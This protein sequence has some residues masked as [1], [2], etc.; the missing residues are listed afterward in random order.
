MIPLET[1]VLVVGAGPTGLALSV[2]LQQAGVR[3]LTVD[4]MTAGQNTSRAAVIHAHTLDVLDTLGV[5][6]RLAGLGL[7]LT[8]FC[9]RDQDHRLLSL[10]FGGLA[11]KH[12]YLV[13]LP[14]DVTEAVLTERLNEIGGTVH[15]GCTLAAIEQTAAGIV[16]TVETPEGPAA[17]RARYAIG[18]DG[19][20]SAVRAAA[21]ID[22]DGGTYDDSFVLADVRMDWPLGADEVSL[23]F[24]SQGL[25]VVAPLPDGSFR[26]VATTANA[27]EQPGTADIQ[28]ILDARGPQGGGSA[29]VQDVVWSSRFRVHHRLARTYCSGRLFLVGDAAHVHSPAGGQGMNCGLVD[30]CVLGQLLTDVIRG[31]RPEAAL[32]LYESLRRPAA[33]QVLGLAGRL[34]VLATLRNGMARAVRNIAF[35][36]L[37]LIGPVKRR[38][39]MNL[40]GL[41]RRRLAELP[42][43]ASAATPRQAARPANA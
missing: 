41:S 31:K 9:I 27:P 15:R 28:A 10:P 25:V 30:A 42:A 39:A 24:S 3:H 34:T 32:D 12:P 22:F 35:R 18:A 2:A 6:D 5:A 1:D 37:D 40:A 38:I 21:G 33:A 13:M 29:T 11:T 20:H 17:V 26:I 43:I 7:K 36:V 23:F 14:Q 19:M 16:A 8:T 4:R